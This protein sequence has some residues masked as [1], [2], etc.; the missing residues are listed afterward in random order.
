MSK[1]KQKRLPY[2]KWFP[3]DFAGAT[4]GWSI[5]AR[6]LYR[7]LI[8]AQWD[9]GGLP[10]DE[11]ALRRIVAFDP[12]M[13]WTA[14]WSVVRSKFELCADGKLRNAKVEQLRELAGAEA[15]VHS[16]NGKLGAAVRWGN[17]ADKPDPDW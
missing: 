4:R 2:I 15:I 17:K 12:D 3:S 9:M 10:N 11:A 7:E 13:D 6:G 14:A 16:E 8:D 5:V 1:P